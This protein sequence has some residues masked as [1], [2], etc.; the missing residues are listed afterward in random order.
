MK[1]NMTRVIVTGL[2]GFVGLSLL[3]TSPAAAEIQVGLAQVDIT[4]PTGGR[5][6]GYSA[7]SLPTASMIR[8]ARASCS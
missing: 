7:R 3:M 8:S 2:A 5:T 1:T 6:T 4:P